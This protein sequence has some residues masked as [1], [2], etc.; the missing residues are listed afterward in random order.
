MASWVGS[1]GVASTASATASFLTSGS[2]GIFS[3]TEFPFESDSGE[4][5]SVPFGLITDFRFFFCDLE[6]KGGGGAPGTIRCDGA[7]SAMF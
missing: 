2:S 3:A 4:G 6:S 7:M 5:A 1:N